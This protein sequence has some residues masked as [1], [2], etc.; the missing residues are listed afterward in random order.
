MAEK[1]LNILFLMADQLAAR[2]LPCYGKSPAVTPHIDRLAAHGAVFDNFYCNSPLCAPARFSMM[3]GAL[4]SRIGAYDNAAD[5]PADIPTIAHYLRASGYRTALAGK[6]HFCG[7]DQLHGFEERLTTDIYPADYGWTPDWEHPEVRPSWYHNMLS[8]LQ[9]GTCV[10]SN[11]LDFDDEV[12]VAAERHL[13]DIARDSDKRPFFAMVSWTHPHDPYANL[14]RYFDLY[15]DEDIPLPETAAHEVPLDSHTLRLRHVM[16]LGR[17]P[18]GEADIRK[19]RRAYFASI[20]YIDAQIGRVCAALEATG[21]AEDTLILFTADHGDMLGERGLWY[22][23]TWFENACRIPL[24]VHAPGRF[25]ERRIKA[26][27]SLVDLLPTLAEISADGKPFAPAAAID[28]RSLLP[29]LQ[30]TGGHDEVIGEYFA[31]GAIAPLMMIRRGTLKYIFSPADPEQLFDL[32]LDP[33][34]R[35]NRATHESAA[36]LLAEFR[37]EVSQRWDMAA[38]QEA[39]IAS[40]KR[41][42]LVYAALSAGRHRSWDFQPMRDASQLYMRNHLE[43]D[44]LEYRTRLPHVPAPL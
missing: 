16:D 31:E 34:E 13:Y 39:V 22:K 42:R 19:A 23:M 28:G 35:D 40:Q 26:A 36:P 43:L 9:A 18:I 24:V 44:D 12:T 30:A 8:V 17:Y 14:P 4:P 10:R 7:P 38:L 33:L 3:A 2:Y 37:Q 21:L 32:S 27:T 25:R 29:H 6:M 41:R 1:R 15:R 11:Q 5:F 20:A